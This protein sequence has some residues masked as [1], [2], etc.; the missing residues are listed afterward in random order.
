MKFSLS[1]KLNVQLI[2]FLMVPFTVYKFRKSFMG[3]QCMVELKSCEFLLLCGNGKFRCQF[4]SLF[5]RVV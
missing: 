3:K 1:F 2:C 5:I 4:I